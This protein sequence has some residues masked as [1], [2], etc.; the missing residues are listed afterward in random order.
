MAAQGLPIADEQ[1]VCSELTARLPQQKRA[2]AV[3]AVAT[4]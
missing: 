3:P 4:A 2:A 1:E